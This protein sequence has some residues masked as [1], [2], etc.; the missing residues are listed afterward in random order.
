MGKYKQTE[1][2]RHGRNS[3]KEWCKRTRERGHEKENERNKIERKKT[4]VR[5]RKNKKKSYV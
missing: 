3:D 2:E 4:W 1:N 5:E